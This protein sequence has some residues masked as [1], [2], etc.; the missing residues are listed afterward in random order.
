MR[1]ED[2]LDWGVIVEMERNRWIR[3]IK[4]VESTKLRAVWMGRLKVVKEESQVS[5]FVTWVNCQ[6]SIQIP[7]IWWRWG[8]PTGKSR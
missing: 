1:G 4:E 2:E 3:G 8:L 6:P 5:G 7:G